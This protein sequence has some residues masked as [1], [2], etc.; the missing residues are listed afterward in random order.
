MENTKNFTQQVDIWGGIEC[1]VNRVGE[2]YF[3]QLVRNGH[4]HRISDLDL[5]AATGIATIRYPVLWE[6]VAPLS[7]DEADW[8]W[9]DERLTRLQELKIRPIVGLVHHGSGPRYA[10]IEREEF[11]LGLGRYAR[12]VAERYPWVDRYTP[13]NEPLTTARFCGLY[14][15]WYPHETK[16]LSFLKMLVHECKGTVLAMQEIRKINPDAKLV[17]TED[18]GQTHSTPMLHY[19]EEFENERRWLTFDLLCGRV[20]PQHWLWGYL[21]WEGLTEK[22]LSFFWENPCPPDIIGINHY[23][24]SERYLDEKL[25][26]YSPHTHGGNG[27]HAYVDVEAIRIPDVQV[28]GTDNLLKQVWERYKLPIAITEVNLGCTRED[29]IR[30]FH[31]VW[32]SARKLQQEGVDLQAITAWAAIGSYDWNTLLRQSTGYYEPGLFDLRS[33]EPRPTALAK[34][35]KEI[36]QTGQASHPVLEGLGWWQRNDRWIAGSCFPNYI[37]ADSHLPN[38][39]RT[40]LITHGNSQLGQALGKICMQRG[41]A[42]QVLS[43]QELDITNFSKVSQLIEEQRPWAIIHTA[44]LYDPIMHKKESELYSRNGDM[45]ASVL[46]EVSSRSGIRFLTFSSDQVFDGRKGQ[47]YLESDAFSAQTAIGKIN[48]L[49]EQKVKSLLPLALIV[50]TGPLF[51][52]WDKQDF[53]QQALIRLMKF[54]SVE[55]PAHVTVSPTYLPDLAHA[56]LD[57]LIDGETGI[58][59]LA[60]KGQ[61]NWAQFVQMVGL[62][63]GVDPNWLEDWYYTQVSKSSKRVHVSAALHSEKAFL[64]APLEDAVRRFYRDNEYK[65]FYL[66]DQKLFDISITR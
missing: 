5:I 63:A 39:G 32:Q 4:T 61:A 53:A 16:G 65:P 2:H 12:L 43:H 55:A 37:C 19:Q 33:P 66:T 40:V 49:A 62:E 36:I 54:Q 58:W 42:Y 30:W 1:T 48:A 6:R 27:R 15:Y 20:T 50:R 52:P 7:L 47:P 60:N 31:Q 28:A 14:G 34:L 64:M 26:L 35:V 29:H 57:L 17:Q 22:E 10:T 46:A 41:I 56:C 25:E 21:I 51:G 8:R 38:G 18:L 44:G 3:D 45:E 11:A 9:S 24:T 59:H 13:V 23:L